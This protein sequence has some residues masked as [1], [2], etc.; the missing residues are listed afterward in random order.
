MRPEGLLNAS[1]PHPLPR[2]MGNPLVLSH[3][4]IPNLTS[5]PKWVGPPRLK[6]KSEAVANLKLMLNIGS[7]LNQY[8]GGMCISGS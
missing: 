2:T 7:L 5:F 3:W 4:R 6:N 1:C 8:H